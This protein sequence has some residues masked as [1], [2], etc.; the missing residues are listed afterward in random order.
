MHLLYNWL[1]KDLPAAIGTCV[2]FITADSEIQSNI[3]HENFQNST[4]PV[5]I[6]FLN[7]LEI[8]I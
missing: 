3:T 5:S 7:L 1:K 8:L 6:T 4:L 2:V